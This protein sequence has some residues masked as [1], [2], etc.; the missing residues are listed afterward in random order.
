MFTLGG[1]RAF[2]AESEIG[3]IEAG[4]RADIVIRRED[5]ADAQPN[6]APIKQLMLISRTK[7]V[8]TVLCNGEVVVRE[9]NLTRLDEAEVYALAKLS[10]KR[11]GE[12]ANVAPRIK[13]PIVN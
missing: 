2:G 3:S 10:A 7:G 4:K 12:R 5:L 8:D 9:G 6:L 11:M 13:W 1:A